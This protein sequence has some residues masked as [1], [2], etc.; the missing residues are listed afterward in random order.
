PAVHDAPAVHDGLTARE[1]RTVLD[2]PSAD[3]P[4]ADD[5]AIVHGQSEPPLGRDVPARAPQ[6]PGS[7]D[8]VS[9]GSGPTGTGT[10]PGL[11]AL[12]S[13]VDHRAATAPPAATGHPVPP[14]RP[15]QPAG[16]DRA[17]GAEA[18]P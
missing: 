7:L 17:T 8:R 6:H 10:P 4:T 15:D 9:V 13:A 1:G 12:S 3:H 18:S 2:R 11:V 5:P 16:A 14:A